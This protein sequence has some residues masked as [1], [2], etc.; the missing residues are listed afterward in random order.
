MLHDT[1]FRL[2][3]ATRTASRRDRGNRV[4]VPYRQELVHEFA[5]FLIFENAK[6][7]GRLGGACEPAGK[8]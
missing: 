5:D 6:L 1:D 4:L 7:P 3:D 2:R 8:L